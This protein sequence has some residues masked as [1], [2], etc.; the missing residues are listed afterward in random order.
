MLGAIRFSL[1]K[2]HLQEKWIGTKLILLQRGILRLMGLIM[3]RPWHLGQDEFD[4]NTSF[5]SCELRLEYVPDGCEKC[6][7]S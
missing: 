2:I 3:M 7:P 5:L 1:L 6:I 4:K